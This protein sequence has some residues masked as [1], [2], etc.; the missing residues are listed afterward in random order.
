MN[1]EVKIWTSSLEE[2][3]LLPSDSESWQCTQ[4]LELK[5]SGELRVEDAFFN[6][7]VALPRAGLLLLANA[8]KNAIYA[9]HI[10]YGPH[11]AATRMDYM[12][13][14][15]VTMPI[16]SITGTSESLPDGEHIVQ[17]Y[18]VQTQAI[19][20]YALALS[21]CLP[22][23][24]DNTEL[25]KSESNVSRAF[26]A[27]NPDGFA[28]LEVSR[29]TKHSEITSGNATLVPSVLSSSA[30][31]APG[32]APPVRVPSSQITTLPETISS[33]LET[34]LS[35]LPSP[36]TVEQ[37]HSASPP[38]PPLSPRLSRMSSG[39]RTPVGSFEPGPTFPDHA[40]DQ[41]VVE[42]SSDRRL[43]TS[44]DAP[45]PCDD[46]RK[47][48]KSVVSND[49]PVV[50]DPPMVF[51]HP[52]HLVTPSE[53]LSKSPSSSETQISQGMSMGEAK[54]QDVVVNNDMASPE[55]EVKVVGETGIDQNDDYSFHRESQMTIAEQKEKSFYSQAS[56]LSIQMAKDCRVDSY[57]VEGAH[58]TNDVGVN[59]SPDQFPSNSD[60]GMTNN[61]FMKVGESETPAAVPQ[62]LAPTSKGKKQK[63]KT[64]QVSGPSSPSPSPFNSTDSSNDPGSSSGAPSADVA[65]S[66][67]LAMQ[68]SLDQVSNSCSILILSS[69]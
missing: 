55:V 45:A 38:P 24:L 52:T 41:P 10:D 40:G 48:D 56:D 59:E 8:K 58:Q 12:A 7:V 69:F 23:P 51:K 9:V 28:N 68:E 29:G 11:P 15:T 5:S 6:Q 16:L 53:I 25:E 64:S 1:R 17:V 21:Q 39:F 19:Q 47:D 60:E 3:W 18:C 57:S 27:A 37:I 4:T 20:Q 54:V 61:A 46:L 67:L 62:S 44:A 49:I 14:F 33:G 30:G 63:G 65:F 13:E 43:E 32:A 26:D 22:P 66:Q 34:K 35:A 42:Y 36:R 31:S 2:G 50:P